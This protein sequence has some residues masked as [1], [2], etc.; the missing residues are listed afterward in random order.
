LRAR[1]E[2]ALSTAA[3]AGGVAALAVSTSVVTASAS[4]HFFATTTTVMPS[5]GG[6]PGTVLSAVAQ[7]AGHNPNGTVDFWLFANGSCS[8]AAIMKTP[9]APLHSKRAVSDSY[10]ATEPGTYGWHARYSGDSDNIPSASGCTPVAVT[11][12]TTASTELTAAGGGAAVANQA[13]VPATGGDPRVLETGAEIPAAGIAAGVMLMLSGSGFGLLARR[14][15]GH[16][17]IR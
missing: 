14:A 12:V 17:R 1:V 5:P 13:P 4:T 7:V 2:L 9:H 15:R 8:G 10:T 11:G 6:P 16:I 3:M